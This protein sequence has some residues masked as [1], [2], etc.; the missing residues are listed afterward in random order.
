MLILI[1]VIIL[2][3]ILILLPIL[4]LILTLTSILFL[5][6]ILNLILIPK[7]IYNSNPNFNLNLNP[8]LTLCNK[9]FHF[10]RGLFFGDY[11]NVDSPEKIYNEISDFASLTSQMET[12]L[13]EFNQMSKTPMS[14]VMFKFAIE[15]I[16]RVSRVLK[17]DN[18]H[19]LLVGTFTEFISRI[20]IWNDIFS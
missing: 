16:S 8:I 9:Y 7:L 14:L 15:H 11:M 1:L 10:F 5:T 6:S 18:G 2:T 17:Q 13:E 19:L 3:S 4:T 20:K 12:Y